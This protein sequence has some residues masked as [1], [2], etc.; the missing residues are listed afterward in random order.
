M[1]AEILILTHGNRYLINKIRIVISS[2][3]NPDMT[4]ENR[5]FS[6]HFHYCLIFVGVQDILFLKNHL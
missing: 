1:M 6:S 5:I 3:N 4:E 2:T